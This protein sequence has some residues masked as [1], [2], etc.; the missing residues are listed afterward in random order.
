LNLIFQEFQ[1]LKRENFNLKLRI[2]FLEE[3]HGGGSNI[4]IRAQSV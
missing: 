1:D 4:E 2:Y 3:N